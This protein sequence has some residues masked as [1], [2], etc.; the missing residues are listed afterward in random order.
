MGLREVLGYLSEES[1]RDENLLS[2]QERELLTNIF[3]QAKKNGAD[4]RVKI[5][6]ESILS[7]AVGYTLLQRASEAAGRSVMQQ[8]RTAARETELDSDTSERIYLGSTPPPTTGPRPPSPSGPPGPRLTVEDRRTFPNSPPPPAT[9]PRPPSPSGPPGPRLTIEDQRTFLNSPP[10]PATGPRPPSP[11]GPPGPHHNIA[12]GGHADH[13]AVAVQEHLESLPAQC[14]IFD[15]FLALEELQHLTEYT[16]AHEENFQVSE[17]ISPGVTG[18]VID[19]EYRRSRV[20]MDLGEYEEIFR[21]RI[22]TALPRVLE[23]LR[24]NA[25]PITRFESQ[26]TASNNGDF[27]RHHSD[28]A[29]EEIARRQLTYVYFFHREPKAFEGGELRLHD[30][31][32]QNGNW[33]STGTYKA[34]RPQQNQIIFFPSGL[35]HEI[36]PVV[37]ASQQFAD[38]RFT[39]NGWLHH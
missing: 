21:A 22:E 33:V 12:A 4:P 15:E 18:G 11:S 37:C 16:L 28:N 36:T 13:A 25:F 32:R 14:V 5:L 10:P 8:V 1:C 3:R 9:G 23:R 30:A 17:V 35:L 27:F 26:I 6:I 39:V 38:S 20:L 19:P 24:M 34:V 31:Y 2:S 7:R 29:E